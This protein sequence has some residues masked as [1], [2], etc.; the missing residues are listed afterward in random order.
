MLSVSIPKLGRFLQCRIVGLSQTKTDCSNKK[1][2]TIPTDDLLN[3]LPS[4]SSMMRKSMQNTSCDQ[5]C[6][7]EKIECKFHWAGHQALTFCEARPNQ[8]IDAISCWVGIEN[9]RKKNKRHVTVTFAP[10]LCAGHYVYCKGTMV[11]HKLVACL[12]PTSLLQNELLK[13]HSMTIL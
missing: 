3:S 4:C 12:S 13:Y 10:G 5:Q 1:N 9:E 7:E 11:S 8:S 6:Q 2:C